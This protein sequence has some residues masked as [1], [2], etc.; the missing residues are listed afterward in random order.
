MGDNFFIGDRNG[1]RADAMESD[2][3]AGFRVPI[4]N[5]FICRPMRCTD[6]CRPTSRPNRAIRVRAE[7]TKRLRR[8]Q[9]QPCVYRGARRF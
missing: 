1:V 8:S 3:N 7:W 5:A 2:R 9:D 4:R 6:T